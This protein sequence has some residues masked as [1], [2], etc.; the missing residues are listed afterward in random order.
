M[1]TITLSINRFTEWLAKKGMKVKDPF[2]RVLETNCANQNSFEH[3][4][5]VESTDFPGVLHIS[6]LFVSTEKLISAGWQVSEYDLLSSKIFV[7]NLVIRFSL[8]R[9]PSKRTSLYHTTYLSVPEFTMKIDSPNIED[10]EL[11]WKSVKKIAPKISSLAFNVSNYL[12]FELAQMS[13]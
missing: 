8:N 5:L 4:F 12:D 9:L 7:T 2:W 10:L 3:E 11:A 6:A 13:V 1:R